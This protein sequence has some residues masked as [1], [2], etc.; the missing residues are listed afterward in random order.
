MYLLG[1][2]QPGK[3]NLPK[4]DPK[5]YHD[6]VADYIDPNK[7]LED[8]RRFYDTGHLD[9]QD[10][11][12]SVHPNE[13]P[14]V[15]KFGDRAAA[16]PG[17]VTSP[18]PE[19]HGIS[20]LRNQFEGTAN[21]KVDTSRNDGNSGHKPSSGNGAAKMKRTQLSQLSSERLHSGK[22]P[23]PGV[24]PKP[25]RR[26]TYHKQHRSGSESKAAPDESNELHMVL[27]RRRFLSEGYRSPENDEYIRTTAS[28]PVD[29]SNFSVDQVSTY[30]SHLGLSAHV[31]AFSEAMVDGRLLQCLEAKHLKDEFRLANTDAVRLVQFIREGSRSKR[32]GSDPAI[33]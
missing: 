11:P 32:L 10:Q 7:R 33:Q 30:L 6:P 26:P 4:T 25:C 12:R 9:I 14:F 1:C 16:G 24:M 8:L 29:V 17:R 2:K 23:P 28:I 22:T 31:P 27:Q 18:G 3:S 21:Q 13:R 19:G 20:W 5:P 15:E